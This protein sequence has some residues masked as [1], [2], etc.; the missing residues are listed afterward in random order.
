MEAEGEASGL[1]NQVT[2]A[3]GGAPA[4][5]SA[6]NPITIGTPTSGGIVKADGWLS[7]ADGT[8]DAQAGSHPYT[9][10]LIFDL[11][12]A[13]N[14][15]NEVE[16]P[17]GEVRD[18]QTKV[19]TGFI[20]D[21]HSF[22][23]CTNVKLLHDECPAASMV[24]QLKAL[25]PAFS[26]IQKQVFDMVPR[27]GTPAELAFEYAGVPVYITFSV[28]TGGDYAIIAHVNPLAQRETYQAMLT[29]WGV[30]EESSRNRW[31]NREGG[32]TQEE[33]EKA[34]GVEDVVD[35]CLVQSSPTIKP[36]LTLPTSCGAP[37]QFSFAEFSAWQ[38]PNARS[39]SSFLTHDASGTPTGFTGCEAL[40]FEQEITASLETNKTDSATGLTVDVKP[41]LGGLES[42]PG[43]RA[44][45][46]KARK[47]RCP[48]AS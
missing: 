38:D 41:S 14:E 33:I 36:F 29:L 32:C 21:L 11:G 37:Q 6:T 2:V 34:S 20:G 48:K 22:P 47:S 25:S 23:Q 45:T 5:A 30:P 1:S 10:T 15:K 43:W 28:Q 4:V 42:P 31:R 44:L 27:P 46:S 18:L 8:I 3:G 17:G 7:N 19:P 9:A 13:L 40:P 35:Y 12:T 16:F 26:S 39:E 24:G